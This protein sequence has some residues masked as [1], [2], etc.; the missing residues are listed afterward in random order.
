MMEA[1]VFYAPPDCFRDE[2]VE[3]PA[4]E[5]HHALRVMRLQTAEP[6]IVVDGLGTAYRG[7]IARAGR[8]GKVTVRLH[9]EIRNF[10]EP[11][12]ILTLAAGLS[13]GSK[14]DRVVERGTELGVKR[15][16]PLLTG[17]SKVK[18]EDKSRARAKRTRLEKVALAAVK[19]CRRSYRPE[20]SLPMH[21]EELLGDTDNESLNLIFHP[22]RRAG[23]LAEVLTDAKAKRVT[24]LVG[25]ESG[26]SDG[27]FDAALKAGYVAVSLGSRILRTENAG[28]VAVAL[29]M[30]YLGELR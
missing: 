21:L 4:D 28:P 7:N 16:I 12:V 5:S 13:T 29:V 9:S 30:S 20:I 17:K 6:V 24:V 22:H 2:I 1:P 3:L 23:S 25:P 18:L 19:Q 8:Q 27:E 14:F 15:F 26:F 10:G 11:A